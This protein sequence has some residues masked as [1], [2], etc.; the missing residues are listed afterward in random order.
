[1]MFEQ[2][3]V[4]LKNDLDRH[5]A[6]EEHTN[7]IQTELNEIENK[8]AYKEKEINT[9]NKYNIKLR[10]YKKTLEYKDE[11]QQS[12]IQALRDKLIEIETV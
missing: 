2:N 6:H 1:M 4:S 8:L 7:D 9:L 11:E 12:E 3:Q 5:K 10:L